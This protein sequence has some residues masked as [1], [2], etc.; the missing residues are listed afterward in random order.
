MKYRLLILTLCTFH[1]VSAQSKEE[2]IKAIRQIF[3]EI[4]QDHTLTTVSLTAED[5]MEESPDNGGEL[6]G[7]FKKDTLCKMVV[8]VGL[9]YGMV[10]QE[11]Y[12]NHGKPVF[13]YET[14]KSFPHTDTSID[15]S[16]LVLNFEGRYYFDEKGIVD[17]KVKGQPRF[18]EKITPAYIK[19]LLK[20][21]QSDAKTLYK[22]LKK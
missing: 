20:Y 14:E 12:Y 18:A 15:N 16:R 7:Y 22:H 1:M 9:S 13:I 10:R 6:I 4:N 17:I 8:E 2:T 11:Y 3:Q 5:F 19:D 21:G